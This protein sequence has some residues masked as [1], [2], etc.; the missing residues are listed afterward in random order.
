MA[1]KRKLRENLL[2]KKNFFNK[3]KVADSLYRTPWSMQKG[4]TSSTGAPEW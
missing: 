2:Q 1:A 4:K 3:N